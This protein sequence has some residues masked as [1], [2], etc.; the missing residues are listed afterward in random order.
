MDYTMWLSL[1]LCGIGVAV[2]LFKKRKN[3]IREK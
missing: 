3:K 1:M 2:I